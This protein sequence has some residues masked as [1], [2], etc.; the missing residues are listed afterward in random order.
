MEV[1]VVSGLRFDILWSLYD[2]IHTDCLIFV[3]EIIENFALQTKCLKC[4]FFS[5]YFRC[6]K[7]FRQLL[8]HH[9]VLSK[10]RTH[11]NYVLKY[12]A[13]SKYNKK[14]NSVNT[15]YKEKFTSIK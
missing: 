9:Q 12:V 14:I 13:T 1:K 11:F 2:I 7:M 8:S 15:K 6:L 4:I 3:T 10:Q 5:F